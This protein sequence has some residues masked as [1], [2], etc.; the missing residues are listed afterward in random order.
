M[1]LAKSMGKLYSDTDCSA[2]K[3]VDDV[4]AA[5]GTAAR[6]LTEVMHQKISLPGYLA[7]EHEQDPECE[8]R[9]APL[10][11]LSSLT[12]GTN[13]PHH[14][15]RGVHMIC[16]DDGCL[17]KVFVN[18]QAVADS[19]GEQYESIDPGASGFQ[20]Q[21]VSNSANQKR[22]LSVPMMRPDSVGHMFYHVLTLVLISYDIVSFPLLAFSFHEQNFARVL[23]TVCTVFWT[24]DLFA[25]FFIGYYEGVTVVLRPAAVIRHYLKTD[26]GLY[27]FLVSIDWLAIIFE[28]AL[29]GGA[30]RVVR[31]FRVLRLLKTFHV[32]RL[33]RIQESLAVLKY[34]LFSEF[35]LAALSATEMLM[36]VSCFCHYFAC[37]WYSLGNPDGW[38]K[39]AKVVDE[40]YLYCLSYHWV[41][42]QFTPSRPP[43]NVKAS[44]LREEVFVIFLLFCGLL[45]FTAFV[46]RM[47]ANVSVAIQSVCQRKKERRRLL[48]FMGKNHVSRQLGNR[49]LNWATHHYKPVAPWVKLGEIDTLKSLPERLMLQLQFEV[50]TPILSTHPLWAQLVESHP[51]VVAKVCC[52]L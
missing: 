41:F 14:E 24:L 38:V 40:F 5:L 11:C 10:P 29:S 20:S 15:D 43:P 1:V 22:C 47:T 48:D 32:M 28:F 45:V 42:S 23:S 25:N 12:S 7:V 44:S 6:H 49:I 50:F 26:F 46:G 3:L 30:L 21:P 19:H 33:G 31:S 2:Q 9:G 13:I 36:F 35:S 17:A 37:A 34:Y 51:A 27:L 8:Q 4:C 16:V 39:N 52:K 18:N